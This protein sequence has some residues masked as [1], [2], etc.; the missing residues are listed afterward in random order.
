MMSDNVE[1]IEQ[2][3]FVILTLLRKLYVL[4]QNRDAKDAKSE[5]YLQQIVQLQKDLKHLGQTAIIEKVNKVY[6]PYL[7]HLTEGEAQ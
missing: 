3:N 6:I 5:E 4:T 7:Q 2:A 1:K